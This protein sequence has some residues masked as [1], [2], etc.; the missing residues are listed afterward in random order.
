MQRFPLRFSIRKTD[1][2]PNVSGFAS[3]RKRSGVTKLSHESVKARDTELVLTPRAQARQ[4]GAGDK[5][6]YLPSSE[7]DSSDSTGRESRGNPTF[8]VG[9]LLAVFLLVTFLSLLKEK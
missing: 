8:V 1:A 3:G 5:F 9:F 4:I 7:A 6:V 2:K